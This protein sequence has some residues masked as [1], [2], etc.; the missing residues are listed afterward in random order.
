MWH[1]ALKTRSLVI[2]VHR[3]FVHIQTQLP[4]RVLDPF[5]AADEDL[6]VLS[7]T[8]EALDELRDVSYV[9]PVAVGEE[10]VADL[11]TG[12][13]REQPLG[14]SRVYDDEGTV[15][16]AADQVAEVVFEIS[17]RGDLHRESSY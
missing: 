2:S 17:D 8:L 6:G 14:V 1:G 11:Q 15:G 13:P 12:E 9:V 7:Q 3:L 4:R 10:H 16:A 5:F